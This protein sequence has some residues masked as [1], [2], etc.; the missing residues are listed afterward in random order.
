VIARPQCLTVLPYTT[1]FR[2]ERR[3]AR[4]EGHA[5]TIRQVRERDN[6]ITVFERKAVLALKDADLER[7]KDP[8]RNAAVINAIR[9]WIAAGRRSEEHTSELQSREKLVCRL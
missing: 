9:A 2:S 4:G 8:E 6:Q 7:I 3:R 5:A 1:L